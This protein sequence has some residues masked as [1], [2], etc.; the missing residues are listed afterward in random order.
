MRIQAK[1]RHPFIVPYFTFKEGK[2][3]VY[4]LMQYCPGG[5]LKNWLNIGD[6]SSDTIKFYMSE[7][8][9][10]LQYIHLQGYVYSDL[11][12]ENILIDHNGHIKICDFGVS[13]IYEADKV[14]YPRNGTL[15]Y[16]SP[17]IISV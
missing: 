10:A 5:N 9:S 1:M 6:F 7:V 17:E 8:L 14:V 13:S 3:D 2:T 15:N 4:I 16:F 12:P 11:K